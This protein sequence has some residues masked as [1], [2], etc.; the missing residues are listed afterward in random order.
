MARAAP[1]RLLL[2]LRCLAAA[3]PDACEAALQLPQISLRDPDAGARLLEAFRD[4]G[5]A[6]RGNR[7]RELTR[8]EAWPDARRGATGHI[9][10]HPDARRGAA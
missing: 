10:R 7:R 8:A 5:G 9:P 3:A 1:L 6:P 4:V 2:A